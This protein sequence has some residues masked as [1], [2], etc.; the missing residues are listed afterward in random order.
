MTWMLRGYPHCRKPSCG[1]IR[2]HVGEKY[3]FIGE[4][5]MK[6]WSGGG[7]NK[8]NHNEKVNNEYV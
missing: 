6:A 7:E 2:E 1:I 3:W 5:V 4:S 8:W